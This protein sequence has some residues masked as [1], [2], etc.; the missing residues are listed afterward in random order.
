MYTRNGNIE[1][2][3][4]NASINIPMRYIIQPEEEKV[5][6]KDEG[7]LED[8]YT[9][10]HETGHLMDLDLEIDKPDEEELAGG[11]IKKIERIARELLAEATAI[12]FEGMLSDYLIENNIYSKEVIQEISNLNMN[13]FLQDARLVYA[14]LLLAKEKTKNGIITLEFIEKLMR[15]NGLSIQ[16]I[17]RMVNN[18]IRD[19]R[20]MLFEKRYA[21]GGLIA[22][23]IIKK[24]NEEGIGT[25]K[26]YLE[27]VSQE[28]FEGAMN[29]L[30]IEL[31]ENGINQLV[32]NVKERIA[33]INTMQR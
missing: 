5:L 10:V 3:D 27:A 29:I 18:I 7:T 8:L 25:L 2:C 9:L 19:P 12:A 4:G 16:Y 24:Y 13:S 17:R 33:K 22:P 26:R 14:K 6:E 30:G 23:T 28:E 15:D 32:F 21:L 11:K 20:G 1:G 31:N